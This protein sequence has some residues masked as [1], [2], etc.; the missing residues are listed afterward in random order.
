MSS[1]IKQAM[2]EIKLPRFKMKSKPESGQLPPPPLPPPQFAQPVTPVQP[3]QPIAPA[4]VPPVAPIPPAEIPPVAQPQPEQKEVTIEDVIVD[5]HKQVS[6]LRKDFDA[7]VRI[8][9]K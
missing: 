5:I 7:Y 1:W 9:L 6:E 4:V 8:Q 2:S 3:V